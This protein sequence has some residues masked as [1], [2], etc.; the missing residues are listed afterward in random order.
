MRVY[1]TSDPCPLCDYHLTDTHGI[2]RAGVICNN[3]KYDLQH[4]HQYIASDRVVNGMLTAIRVINIQI[5]ERLVVLSDD[6][7]TMSVFFTDNEYEGEPWN[8][9][10]MPC[11][12]IE[13]LEA[14]KQKLDIL[15][16]F[17]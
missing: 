17:Q 6:K 4:F 3:P 10:E 12:P 15:L 7:E 14:M 11:I 16:A 9:R 13:S 1:T 2:G 5:G 8:Y